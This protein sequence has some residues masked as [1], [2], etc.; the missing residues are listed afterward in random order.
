MFFGT[1]R[2]VA[3]LFLIPACTGPRGWRLK[4]IGF[5]GVS[6]HNGEWVAMLPHFYSRLSLSLSV[7]SNCFWNIKSPRNSSHYLIGG[8]W[9]LGFTSSPGWAWTLKILSFIHSPC[10]RTTTLL[11]FYIHI[12]PPPLPVSTNRFGNN[13]AFRNSKFTR[14]LGW[15][16]T[17]K[18]INR[19][20][21]HANA[22]WTMLRS[23]SIHVFPLFLS[24]SSRPPWNNRSCCSPFHFLIGWSKLSGS[25]GLLTAINTWLPSIY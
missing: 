9:S 13:R 7:S 23:F 18:R 12:F 4:T 3:I 24:V 20:F 6:M 19:I 2:S 17:L 10:T 22:R 1:A 11:I 8:R 25:L 16:C 14:V 21:P 15:G 5:T